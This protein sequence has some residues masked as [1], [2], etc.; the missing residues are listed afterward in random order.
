MPEP[1]DDPL[2]DLMLSTHGC[3]PSCGC[4]ADFHIDPR[5]IGGWID[6]FGEDFARAALRQLDDLI[7][8]GRSIEDAVGLQRNR[9]FR[10]P[11]TVTAW[12]L[13]WRPAIERALRDFLAE[14]VPAV[15]EAEATRAAA[16]DDL[17]AARQRWREREQLATYAAREDPRWSATEQEQRRALRKLLKLRQPRDPAT[18]AKLKSVLESARAV[19]APIEEACRARDPQHAAA[20]RELRA[21]ESALAEAERRLRRATARAAEARPPAA[22]PHNPPMHRT[23]PAV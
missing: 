8:R 15:A 1:I 12:L 17:A 23:G 14:D 20:A 9:L 18:E 16:S 7:A 4:D 19:M 13:R 6:D 5:G 21:A 10:P 22:S 3:D 2:W 11:E